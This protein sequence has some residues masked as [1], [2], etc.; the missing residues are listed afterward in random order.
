MAESLPAAFAATLT[1]AAPPQTWPAPLA[2]LWWLAK[3]PCGADSAAWQRAHALV[4]DAA[5][6]D[7]AWV[8][9]HLHRIE[10]DVGNARYWYGRAGREESREALAQ[11]RA[12]I[13]A[14]LSDR[15]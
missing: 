10:G 2:A 12:A 7:A 1:E 15:A 5:G 11:E 4:Q 9:A 6:P 14:A 8:H 3:G 13:I